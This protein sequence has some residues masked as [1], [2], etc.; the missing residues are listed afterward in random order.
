M[1]S[2]GVIIHFYLFSTSFSNT[3]Y[4]IIVFLENFFINVII[5]FWEKKNTQVFFFP[6]ILNEIKYPNLKEKFNNYPHKLML[7]VLS[8]FKTFLK[9]ILLLK[10]SL[11]NLP[12]GKHIQAESIIIFY[13]Q[14]IKPNKFV[15]T[16]LVNNFAFRRHAFSARKYWVLC[17][18]FDHF[19]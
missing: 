9:I 12:T 11:I 5:R 17:K 2:T 7:L 1:E 6:V 8:M 16:T 18:G 10:I 3:H 19:H 13:D 15:K 14:K 4:V